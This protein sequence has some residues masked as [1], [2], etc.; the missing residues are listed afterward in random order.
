MLKLE[1]RSTSRLE[2]MKIACRPIRRSHGQQDEQIGRSARRTEDARG[3]ANTPNCDRR[4]AARRYA[5]LP[6]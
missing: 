5:G 1:L 6:C 2:S 3:R 4:L